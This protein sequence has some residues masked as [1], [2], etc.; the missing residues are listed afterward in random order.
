MGF[1]LDSDSLLLPI[2]SGSSE[3]SM[4]IELS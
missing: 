1:I 4:K 3:K 2:A